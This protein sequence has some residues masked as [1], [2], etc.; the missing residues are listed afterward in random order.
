MTLNH[1]IDMAD[2]Y[3]NNMRLFEATGFGT[4]LLTD[5]KVNLGEMFEPGR[6]VVTYRTAAEC[7]E[8][9]GYYVEHDAERDAI[10]RA[11]QRRTLREHSYDQRMQELVDVVARYI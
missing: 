2:G 5:W 9:I 11:G 10:A 1:H 3:A 7:A 4:L 6:E 8:L